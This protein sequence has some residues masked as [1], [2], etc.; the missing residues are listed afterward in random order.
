MAFHRVPSW[1]RCLL[2]IACATAVALPQETP[3]APQP[4]FGLLSGEI[5]GD[6]AYDHIRHLTLY[7]SPGSGSKGYRDK[8]RWIF[9]KAKQVGLEDVRLI[10]DIKGR[11]P[12]WTAVSAELFMLSPEY[13]RL[14]S[15]DEAAV[16]VAT[17][18]RSGTWEGELVDVGEGTRGEDYKGKDVKGKMVLCSGSP[19]A[20]MQQAVFQRGALGVVYYNVA[21]GLDYPDQVAWIHLPTQA[22]KEKQV[23]FGF[24]I[25]Y[26]A[27]ME[28]KRRLAAGAAGAA[29]PG[30]FAEGSRAGQKVVLRAT[31]NSEFSEDA[32]QWM[33]E[34]WI[35]GTKIHDQAIVLTAHIQ[36]EK[37]S[38][39]DDNSGLA[40]LLEIGRALQK[41][42]REGRLPRPA[43]DIRLW[44]C[45]EIS[46]EY[47]YFAAHPEERGKV[48]ANINQDMVGARQS[49]GARIQHITRTPDSRPSYLNDVMESIALTV[50]R[51]NTG[52]LSAGQAGSRT[53][54]S[55]PI[56]ARF[57]T[58]DRYGVEIVPFFTNTD[59][60]VFNDVIIGVPGVTLTNWPDPYI[61]SSD[62]DLWQ[63]DATQLQRNAFVVAAAS[64]YL[65]ALEPEGLPVLAA[66]VH[67]GVGRSLSGALARATE[68][69]ALA[70]PSMRPG[71]YHDGVNLIEQATLRA[72]ATLDSLK[73]FQPGARLKTQLEDW[74]KD[75]PAAGEARRKALGEH[76]RLLT[77]QAE[78]PRKELSDLEERMAAKVPEIA[79]GVAE[80][81]DKRFSLRGGGLHGVMAYELP[82]FVDGRRSCLDIY[83]A[84]RAEAQAAGEWYYGTVTAKAVDEALDRAVKA[85]VLRLKK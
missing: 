7:H 20:V 8:T 22:P 39:N 32:N 43:R 47:A 26:R 23:T 42:I 21:R 17:N 41:L 61:H 73:V 84:L 12:G 80:Y 29:I 85:G 79:L 52:Y 70:P 50:A 16:A 56:V 54:F 72:A 57:G 63:V 35:K 6:I 25:S 71:A 36:E 49:L 82:N 18:S 5:S 67:S 48:L 15:Y 68:M 9:E 74:K 78:P 59:H 19:G 81:I 37:Y 33:V 44:W 62:D 53:P 10:E 38:A 55:K 4:A 65:A 40:S 45:N 34:G 2:L 11:G 69:L 46:G 24:S 83:R 14:A 76:Y 1:L 75:L 27:G 77:A 3:L 28:L 60:M 31:V 13:R 64:Y 58:R 66:Q 30:T 51:G